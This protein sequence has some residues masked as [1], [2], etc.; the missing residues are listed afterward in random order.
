MRSHEMVSSVARMHIN[1]FDDE[2]S[3]LVKPSTMV[4]INYF[5]SFFRE[6]YNSDSEKYFALFSEFKISLISLDSSL[7][8]LRL[9]RTGY[10]VICPKLREKLVSKLVTWSS[11]FFNSYYLA[12][13][14]LNVYSSLFLLNYWA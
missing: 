9:R 4:S 1:V 10:L 2:I 5:S 13:S 12:V 7:K 6:P 3:F 8:S 11:Y 14:L